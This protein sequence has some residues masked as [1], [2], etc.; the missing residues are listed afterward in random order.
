MKESG[1]P[2]GFFFRDRTLKSDST[3]VFCTNILERLFHAVLALLTSSDL[4]THCFNVQFG[5]DKIF[6]P[7]V[8]V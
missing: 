8:C 4:S 1:Q 6:L 7:C 5:L 3:H 2:V